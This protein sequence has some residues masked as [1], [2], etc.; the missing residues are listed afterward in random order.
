[1]NF[2]KSVPCT[3]LPLCLFSG[4]APR[5]SDR[6]ALCRPSDEGRQ[7]DDEGCPNED[8]SSDDATGY[9]EG[10]EEAF[11]EETHLEVPEPISSR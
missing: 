11:A 1:M 4:E 7:M 8:P 6:P 5:L 9:S 10:E 2:D 3:P